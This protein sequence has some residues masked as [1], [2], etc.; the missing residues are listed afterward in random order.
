MNTVQV[1]IYSTVITLLFNKASQKDAFVLF[2]AYSFYEIKIVDLDA[3]YYYSCASLLNLI[4]GLILHHKNKLAAI[5]AYSLIFVNLLGFY[6]WYQYLPSTIYDNISLVILIAQ[7]ITIL[8]KGLLNGLG[9]Y[10]KYIMAKP[11]GFDSA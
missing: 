3:I 11:N 6:I 2:V 1:I 4:V 10:F 7:L 8:P 5:C 9:Y